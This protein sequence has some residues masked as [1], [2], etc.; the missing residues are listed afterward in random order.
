[1]SNRTPSEQHRR[2][3]PPDP[4]GMNYDRAAWADK[5]ISAFRKETGMDIDTALLDLLA[6][7]M[8]WSDRA[9]Y[10]FDDALSRARE[11]Y[12]A[13]TAESEAA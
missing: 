9:R 6:D 12:Q 2:P 3:I 1:M 13:E 10:D 8:H 4:E 5:A 11:H 7:L